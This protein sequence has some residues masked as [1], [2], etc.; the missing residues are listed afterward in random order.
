[1]QLSYQRDCLVLLYHGML[2]FCDPVFLLLIKY[3]VGRTDWSNESNL[4][5][6]VFLLVYNPGVVG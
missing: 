4:V 2:R 6:I 1:M 5:V 3:S